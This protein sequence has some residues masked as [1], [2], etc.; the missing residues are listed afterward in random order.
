MGKHAI[1]ITQVFKA[2]RTIEIEVEAADEYQA[3][4][5]VSSG[6]IDMPDFDDP[7]WKTGWDLQNEEVEPA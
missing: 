4:K 7:R 2:V 5:V 1:R 6:A 3:A